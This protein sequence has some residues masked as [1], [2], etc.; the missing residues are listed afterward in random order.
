MVQK[1]LSDAVHCKEK[2]FMLNMSNICDLIG[3]FHV[4]QVS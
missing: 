2:T 3:G 1:T 4:T